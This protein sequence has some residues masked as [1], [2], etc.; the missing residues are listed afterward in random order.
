MSRFLFFVLILAN[1]AFAGHMYLQ[2]QKPKDALPSETNRDAMKILSITDSNK[3]RQEIGD[4]KKLVES[5]IGA[6]CA[7]FTVKPADAARAQTAF[8]AMSLGERLITRNI[9]E[10]SRFAVSLPIQRDRKA[11]D[12]LVAALKKAGVKDMLVMADF[13]I[14]L[15]LFSSED[16]AKRLVS[17]LESKVA[18]Q[19]KGIT[20]TAKNPTLKEINFAVR[21][22]DAGLVTR[23]AT[24][25]RDIEGANIKGGD[26]PA[27]T[28]ATPDLADASAD[29]KTLNK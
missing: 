8:A 24:I 25:Q 19:I 6:K 5:M 20:I 29:V 9:E 28:T 1:L 11:A 17:E 23:L 13:S 26:C 2:A 4:A 15:G 12:V 16:A 7:I 21:D 14:S 10:F 18:L 3:A 27:T 22:P